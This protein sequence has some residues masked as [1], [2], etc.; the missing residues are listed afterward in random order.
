MVSRTACISSLECSIP[1]FIASAP[2]SSSTERIWPVTKST[3]MGW[4]PVTP[5][6]FSSTTA[7]TGRGSV[8]A[9]GCECLVGLQAGASA[10]VAA[11]DGEDAPVCFLVHIFHFSR[12]HA[13]SQNSHSIFVHSTKMSVMAALVSGAKGCLCEFVAYVDC[14]LGRCFECRGR[15]GCQ[16]RPCM[17]LSGRYRRCIL[18][19]L[20]SG[21]PRSR[22]EQPAA[23]TST[24]A[25]DCA[26]RT[27]V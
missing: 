3:G 7:T 6:V 20:P 1:I 14:P 9:A 4:T 18:F 19:R 25:Y 2:M 10:G 16:S 8:A 26:L 27:E 5:T 13:L 24:G 21:K 23:S 17:G 22:A 11:C 12:F 15:H